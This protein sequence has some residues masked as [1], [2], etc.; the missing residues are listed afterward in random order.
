MLKIT[1]VILQEV[2]MLTTTFRLAREAGACSESYRRY[3]RHVGE[4]KKYG[5]DTPINL[6]DVLDVCGL[7]DALWALGCC[8]EQPEAEKL[9][10]LLAADYAEHILLFFEERWPEDK[11]PRQAIEVARRYA[12]GNATR[13]ELAAAWAAAWAAGAAAGAAAW[14]AAW[15]AGAAAGA[16]AW[17]AAGAA[18]WAAAWAAARAAAWAATGAAAGAAAWAAA[19]AAERE[20]QESKFKEYLER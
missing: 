7:Y 14:A 18:A 11:R 9:G 15:A 12:E 4:V 8:R 6:N 2:N 5:E 1:I 10:R 16:A 3:A 20:W 19:G 13:E 17:A